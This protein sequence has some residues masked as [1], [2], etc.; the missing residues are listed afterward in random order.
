MDEPR[1]DPAAMYAIEEVAALKRVGY[2]RVL[3]AIYRGEVAAV[4]T[5]RGMRIVGVDAVR[6]TPEAI[7]PR[8]PPGTGN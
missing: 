2:T 8:L 6:W 4:R 7:D 1:I 5:P 3:V